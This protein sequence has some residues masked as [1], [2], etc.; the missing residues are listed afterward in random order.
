MRNKNYFLLA[1]M[2]VMMLV[3]G[4]PTKAKTVSVE[5]NSD[6][7]IEGA[8]L[9]ATLDDGTVLGFYRYW[10][11]TYCLCGAIST[12]TE[13][14]VPDSILYSSTCYAVESIG[15]SRCDFDNAQSVTSLIL[16]ATVTYISDIPDCVKVLHVNNYISNFSSN[17]LS[18]LDKVLVP[19]ADLSSF[20]GNTSWS[21]YVLINA[22]GAEPLKVT[23]NMTKAGEFAQLLLQQID[24]WYKVNELTVVGE[25]NTDD[26]NVFKRMKQLTKLDLSKAVITD[27]PAQ[28]DGSN[29]TGG[30]HKGFNI[31]E[32][33]S[34]P[35]INSIGD[36][37]F[38][39][40]YRLKSVT[41]PK[42]NRIGYG[43]FSRLGAKQIT[44]P[45]GITAI[46]GY[47]FY[48]SELESV[49]IPSS[50]NKISESCFYGCS[51]LKT[52]VIPASVSVIGS[53]AFRE[54][55]LTS[56]DLP[57]VTEIEGDAFYNCK[58]LSNVK[59]AAGL[60]YFGG[61]PFRGCTALTEI[62]LPN[63]FNYAYYG[64]FG[65]CT[66]IKKFI[67][68]A[69]VPPANGYGTLMEGCDMTDVK[70]YVPAMAIDK[71][72][73]ED[74]WKRF[75]TILPIE[76]KTS[77]A[78]IYDDATI[79]D[80]VEFTDELNMFLDWRNQHRNGTTKYWCGALD[81]NG[82]SQLSMH[83]YKQYH[84]LGRASS[85]SPYSYEAHYTS[86]IPNG[87]MRADSVQT[88]MKTYNSYYWYF[89]SLPYDV[90]VS[91]ITYDNDAQFVIRKYSGSNRAQMTGETWLNLTPDSIMHA[92]EGYIL[93]CSK[94][95]CNFSFPAINNT[96][97]NKVF[98]KESVVM[99]LGEYL[100][101]F[102][103]DRSWNLIGN[104]YP[105]Y[106]D[107][108]YMNF[109]APITV[110]NRYYE[111]YDAYSPIDDD[112]ILHP[113]QAFF[114]QRPVDK[115]SITFDKAGRQK[116][117]TVREM[118]AQAKACAIEKSD[119]QI[120]NIIMSD[121][122]MTDRTRF[123]MN[124]NASRSYELDKDAS[125]FIAGNNAAML[126]YTVENGVRYAINERPVSDGVVQLGFYA[127]ADG[128]YT[129]SLNT[130]DKE[131]VVLTDN[132]TK[133]ETELNGEYRFNASAGY[134]DAR[135]S[136]T[137]GGGT[138]GI[139][140]VNADVI[141][142]DAPYSIYTVGGRLVGNYSAGDKM[143]LPK[144]VY[145]ISS[146]DVKHKIVVK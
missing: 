21:N 80:A 18:T 9:T 118:P 59:F 70:L 36:Y 139:G 78:Y 29:S 140:E 19:E 116:D 61:D 38:A 44:L 11:D 10:G 143:E 90:K 76:D 113:T 145:I 131:K 105:C 133:V 85:S 71:Y 53:N 20:Y 111:R 24:D 132:E 40:C 42:V 93:K 45:D 103:H 82:N 56:V 83:N 122:E 51:H 15:Y 75:Y 50:I 12:Q 13:I 126:V 4:L 41:M 81:Y 6:S 55:G 62:D 87:A 28:F 138:T 73:A 84:Y 72:R 91:D 32:E 142:S 65:G 96:N 144:G 117:A 64:S 86:L 35:E 25:L 112:F 74:S 52:A 89:I 69:V 120:Y 97:K 57:G 49:A 98:E 135:F 54:S 7:G 60:S 31:L 121:G 63:T 123:V 22:E 34:L 2:L 104:P 39:D 102:E 17:Q 99:P 127:P 141:P 101:E 47:A 130:T 134:N 115:A 68:R 95:E 146:K 129:L 67:C 46:D 3:N 43:A 125:K 128:D 27:I 26:L 114:V 124:D 119:R 136:L 88:I 66:N 8:S 110:W 94:D 33:L 109:T 1:L 23:I 77:Y 5:S 30:Y 14:S 16:P 37:A 108:R 92:Y 107:T 100:S 79:N 106:Y 48:Y 137:I 58:Q